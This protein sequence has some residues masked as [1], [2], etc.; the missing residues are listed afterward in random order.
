MLCLSTGAGLTGC[1]SDKS[2]SKS[3]SAPTTAEPAA[4]DKAE[5][6]P[7]DVDFL[8]K[9]CVETGFSDE[10]CSC[11][12]NEA[13]AILGKEIVDKMRKAPA[14]DDPALD[15][16][17]KGTEISKIMELVEAG[18]EKCGVEG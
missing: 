2:K 9:A 15:G 5:A 10:S 12:G 1:S 3:E 14:D 13:K 8:V 6:E 16:Y 17:Y 11:V 7:I 4:P 18:S